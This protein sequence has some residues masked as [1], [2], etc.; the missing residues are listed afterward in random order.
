MEYETI[1]LKSWSEISE[2]EIEYQCDIFRGHWDASWELTSSLLRRCKEVRHDKD[3]ISFSERSM[4]AA[5]QRRLH[6]YQDSLPEEDDFVAWLAIMQHHGTCTRLIDFTHSFYV[7]LFF[8]T[9]LP[10]KESCVWAIDEMWLRDAAEEFAQQCDLKISEDKGYHDR[11]EINQN[12]A[13]RFLERQYGEALG[14]S[15][16]S[17]DL[18]R[19]VFLVEPKKQI[20]R[21]AI[22]QGL[23]VV[24]ADPTVGLL[25]NI[26]ALAKRTEASQCDD[27]WIECLSAS[28]KKIVVPVS[29]NETVRL[30]LAAMNITAETLFP[31]IDGFARAVMDQEVFPAFPPPTEA[32]S[33]A[34]HRSSF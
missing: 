12:V 6:H 28:V 29:L 32:S 33:Q 23:F 11:W 9:A 20:L 25:E 2:L 15:N 34:D 8:A 7:A 26:E 10:E 30:H 3:E 22:Q 16:G 4:I 18:P 19:G 24:P 21:L 17:S 27:S 13:N 1:V 5:F 14:N 31:G